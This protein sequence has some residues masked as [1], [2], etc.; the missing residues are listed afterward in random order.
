M[1]RIYRTLPASVAVLMLVTLS[2][3]YVYSLDKR[4]FGQCYVSWGEGVC[5]KEEAPA[6][7]ELTFQ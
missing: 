5:L 3:T 7:L 2:P 6:L 1:L 4:S